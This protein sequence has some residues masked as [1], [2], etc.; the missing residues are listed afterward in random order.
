MSLAVAEKIDSEAPD[1]PW[2]MPLEL[3]SALSV[4][5]ANQ[6]P[7]PRTALEEAFPD[8]DCGHKPLAEFVI[9]QIRVAKRKTAGGII[10]AAEGRDTELDNTQV[11]KVVA[12][13]PMAF[14]N[15]STGEPGAGGAWYKVGDYVR[16]PKY[17]GDR[18]VVPFE[19]IENGQKV[20]DKVQFALFKDLDQR[21][22]VIG[23]PL[24]IKAAY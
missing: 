3:Q 4:V 12:I 6:S 2:V 16:A 7:S 18:W 8:V 19:R 11:A 13:G 20:I 1:A 10:L 23:D 9:V 15:R 17:G 5:P 24:K 21:A 22:L 14:T